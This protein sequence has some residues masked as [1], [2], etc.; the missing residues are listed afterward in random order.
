MSSKVSS[1]YQVCSRACCSSGDVIGVHPG[2]DR[3]KR[4]CAERTQQLIQSVMSSELELFDEV[5]VSDTLWDSSV[6]TPTVLRLRPFYVA[7]RKKSKRR[8]RK[9]SDLNSSRLLDINV[10]TFSDNRLHRLRDQ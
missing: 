8:R 1:R 4:A 7:K 9:G 6:V 5:D 2:S 3:S 10:F